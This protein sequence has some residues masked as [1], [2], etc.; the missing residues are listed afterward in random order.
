[1]STCG[2]AT[3]LNALEPYFWLQPAVTAASAVLVLIAAGITV[4]Q[5]FVADRKDQWWKR[6]QW[7]FDL[8][9]TQDE[10]S[11][12]LGLDVLTQQMRTT[13]ADK[14]DATMVA[15]VITPWVD[16]YQRAQHTDREGGADDEQDAPQ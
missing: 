3:T 10:D 5:R 6:T 8:L 7:A 2:A 1:M 15:D 4:R 14:E 16:S 9:L 13:V 12:V 11:V